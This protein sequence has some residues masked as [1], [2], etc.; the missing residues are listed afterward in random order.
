MSLQVH[1]LFICFVLKFSV[2]KS[3]ANVNLIRYSI[4]IRDSKLC[5]K[6]NCKVFFRYG[7]ESNWKE[8][9]WMLTL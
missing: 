9:N 2:L 7:K 6:N 3:Y 4:S 5:N 1:L 8:L